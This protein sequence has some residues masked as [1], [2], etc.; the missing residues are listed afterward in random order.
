[1]EK[2]SFQWSKCHHS[3]GYSVASYLSTQTSVYRWAN[4]TGLSGSIYR[5]K[6]NLKINKMLPQN[7]VHSGSIY[8][9]KPNFKINKMLSSRRVYHELS[10]RSANNSR[11]VSRRD[12]LHL[13]RYRKYTQ[14]QWKQDT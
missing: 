13:L 14:F 11:A 12:L 2:T 6:P 7:G 1:M 8:R 5:E 9:E 10:S 4:S 3:L